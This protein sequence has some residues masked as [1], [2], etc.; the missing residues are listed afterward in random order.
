MS[1]L[2]DDARARIEAVERR[3][4]TSG[5]D[6]VENLLDAVEVLTTKID[7]LLETVAPET[8]EDGGA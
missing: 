2:E 8:P 6:R 7:A 4:T 5:E 3:L 1:N